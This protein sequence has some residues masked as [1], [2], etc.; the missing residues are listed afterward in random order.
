MDDS[1]QRVILSDVILMG[2]HVLKKS[3]ERDELLD[4]ET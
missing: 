2:L 1:D 4:I 3:K